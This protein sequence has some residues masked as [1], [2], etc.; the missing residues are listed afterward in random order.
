[1]LFM[2]EGSGL[3][4]QA[5]ISLRDLCPLVKQMQG[6]PKNDCQTART[7]I[8]SRSRANKGRSSTKGVSPD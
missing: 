1:M 4:L 5:S 3:P 6:N 7:P 2:L 8:S